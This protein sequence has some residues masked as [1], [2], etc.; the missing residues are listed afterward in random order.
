MIKF[1]KAATVIINAIIIRTILLGCSEE[2]KKQFPIM[3]H[4]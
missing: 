2:A 4:A 3:S 1:M